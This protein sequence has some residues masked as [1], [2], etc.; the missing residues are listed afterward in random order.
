MSTLSFIG[1]L[2]F[3]LVLQT[4]LLP[5]LGVA[6]CAVPLPP[7]RQ[8]EKHAMS[9]P[10]RTFHRP[11]EDVLADLPNALKSQGFGVLTEIDMQATLLAKLGVTFRRYR[12]LG[13][14]NPPL[15][16]QALSA[17][18]R[19]GVAMPCN[20]VIYERED[21]LTQVVAVDPLAT[22]AGI[23]N[24]ALEDVARQVRDKLTA[25]LEAVPA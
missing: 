10:T 5:K 15:A 12:I 13:A 22:M 20:V 6:T 25:A 21:G 4:W 23:G 19:V 14:C 11:F 17:D 1:L 7:Q 2:A 18:L 8:Q 24:A 3:W 9:Q 16:H